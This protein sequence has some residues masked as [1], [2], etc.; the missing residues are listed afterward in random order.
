M[1]A[2]SFCRDYRPACSRR[3]FSSFKPMR[4]LLTRAQADAELTAARLAGLGH[5][6]LISPVIE[7]VPIDAAMPD[8]TFDA[9]VATSAHALAGGAMKSLAHIPLYAV[10]ERTRESAERLG[11]TA[12][13]LVREDAKQLIAD[14]RGSDLRRLLY[15]AGH[16]RKPDVEAAA[17]EIGFNLTIIETYVARE[18]LSLSEA[19]EGGLR[20][21]DIDAVLHYSRRSAELFIA[22]AQ[23]M[24]LWEQM[25]KLRH[26]VLSRDVAEPLAAAG[27]LT[28]IAAHPDEDHLLALLSGN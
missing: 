14:L 28:L 15:L 2:A 23:R 20:A 8:K 9:I 1:P 25:M 6:T 10:G 19:A 16:N 21:G 5:E 7:I 26:F 24:A 22:L 18:K 3:D 11:W 4:I 13:I 17:Q 27:A 12:P